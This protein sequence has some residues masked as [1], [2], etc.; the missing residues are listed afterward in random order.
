M[1]K[2]IGYRH[3]VR[4]VLQTDGALSLYRGA[5]AAGVGSIVFRSTGF[6]VFE[7]FFTR[8]ENTES[9]RFHIPFTGGLEFRTVVAGWLSGSFRALLECPFE[10]VKVKRQTG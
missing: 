4:T 8:W 5:L 2:Q 1:G 7:L 9:M 3:A 10:Y 6:S